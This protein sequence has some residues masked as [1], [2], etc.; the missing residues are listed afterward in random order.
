MQSVRQER[1]KTGYRGSSDNTS[2][3]D[4][5]S[6]SVGRSVLVDSSIMDAAKETA[7]T[8]LSILVHLLS[9]AAWWRM[10]DGDSRAFAVA[11]CQMKSTASSFHLPPVSVATTTSRHLPDSSS[12]GYFRSLSKRAWDRTAPLQRR[13]VGPLQTVQGRF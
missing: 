10:K 2:A 13:L 4:G 9:H 6:P 11:N 12:S 3:R 5:V 7:Q 1:H 8:V